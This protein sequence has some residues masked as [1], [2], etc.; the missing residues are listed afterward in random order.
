MT[1]IDSWSVTAATN[2]AA[3]GGAINWAE[4][5][6]PSTV[7]NSARQMMTD[8]RNGFNDLIWFQYGKGDQGTSNIATPCVYA[9]STSFTVAGANVT[10]VYHVG[11]RIKAV[12]VSTGTIYGSV[13]FASFSIN[14][15]V[16]VTWDSG[17]L[18]NETLT[19]YLSQVP[20]TGQPVSITSLSGSI[21]GSGSIVFSTSPTITSPT[22]VSPTITSGLTVDASGINGVSGVSA[23]VA[24]NT[25]TVLF[26][27]GAASGVWMVWAHP[28]GVG[29]H[30]SMAIYYSA[31]SS[32]VGMVLATQFNDSVGA[33]NVTFGSGTNTG[34]VTA[35]RNTGTGTGTITWRAVR[36]LGV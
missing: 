36:F 22:L 24:E 33:N 19:V 17:S 11:R 21:T 13:S 32:G 2:A 4:G 10:A 35:L 28:T 14:T 12:G 8:V 5:Q 6:A 1:G 31:N 18:A 27:P 30:S 23:S 20:V 3:D 26:D 16:G 34:G 29:D 7:N 15:T 9:S 25:L